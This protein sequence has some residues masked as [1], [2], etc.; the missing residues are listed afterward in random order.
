MNEYIKEE[1]IVKNEVYEAL[2]DDITCQICFKLMI[3]PM[4][5]PNCQNTIC[6]KCVDDWKKKGGTCPNG[7][8]S[9]FQK[10]IE[11]NN[12]IFKIKFKCIKGCG[13][14]I[15]FGDLAKHS[16]VCINSSKNKK[17]TRISR[18]ELFKMKE[19]NIEYFTSKKI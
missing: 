18:E 6:N 9:E 19:K 7:C 17:M 3:L 13:K 2:K 15:L 8:K 16:S 11:K 1:N 14:E 4:V 12:H 10:V 5:C